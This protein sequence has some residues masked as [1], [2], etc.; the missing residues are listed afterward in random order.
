MKKDK[1]T[2]QDLIKA[3]VIDMIQE[4]EKELERQKMWKKRDQKKEQP[5]FLQKS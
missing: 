2:P 5:S 3:R 4:A 1:E